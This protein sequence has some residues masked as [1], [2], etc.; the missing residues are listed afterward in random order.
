M[1]KSHNDAENLVL[2]LSPRDMELLVNS[3]KYPKEPNQLLLDALTLYGKYN[4][5]RHNSTSFLRNC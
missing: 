5:K 4:A 3:L 2:K 1:E